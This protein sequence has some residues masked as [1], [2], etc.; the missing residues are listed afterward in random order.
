VNR[1]REHGTRACY[2]RGPG[3]GTGKG[4]RCQACRRANRSRTLERERGLVRGDWAPWADAGPVRAHVGMLMAAGLTQENVA[5]LA[6]VRPGS[7][8]HLMRGS[9]GKPPARHVRPEVAR[10]ILA[11]QPGPL[12]GSGLVGSTG[13]LRR[14]QALVA[15]GWSQRQLAAALPMKQ[16]NFVIL[17]RGTQVRAAT[18]VIVRELYDRLWDKTPPEDGPRAPVTAR[19]ARA[20]AA[21]RDWAPPLAWDDDTIDDPS[22]LAACWRRPAASRWRSAD[23]ADDAAELAALGYSRQLAA[24]RLGVT[25][26]ALEKAL[27]RARDAAA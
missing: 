10:K 21:A 8:T 2:L 15:I 18:A 1:R 4:C 24:E 26:A 23:L 9:N 3:P 19:H 5:A 6:D 25:K 11:V 12:P 14:L 20:Y 17:M 13:T 22:A 16:Q 7:V 27:E